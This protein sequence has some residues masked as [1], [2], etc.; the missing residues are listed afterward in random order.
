V[1][2]WAK[3][4]TIGNRLINARVETAAEKPAFRRAFARRRC[5][6]PADGYFE[7]WPAS[8]RDGKQVKQPYFIRPR[9]GEVLAMAGLYEFWRDPK[10]DADDPEAWLLS[11]TVLTTEA[12]DEL[13]VIHDRMPLMVDPAGW[14]TWLDPARQDPSDVRGVLLPARPGLLEAFPVS[15]AVN[16]VRNEGPQLLDPVPLEELPEGLPVFV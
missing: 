15:R 12:E 14:D 1:P 8:G 7:W 4:P 16:N 3:D 2:S 11:V 6:L 9:D 13:G 5:L 10:G